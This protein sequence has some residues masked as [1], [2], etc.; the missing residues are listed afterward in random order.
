MNNPPFVILKP[1][2]GTAAANQIAENS[3]VV[4]IPVIDAVEPSYLV[5]YEGNLY[6]AQ[7]LTELEQRIK[8]AADRMVRNYPTIAR[9]LY[10]QAEFDILGQ[11]SYSFNEPGNHWWIQ[12]LQACKP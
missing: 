9:G 11:V 1:K 12:M 6:N 8:C 2:P 4:G 10:P 5:Y 7:N 3:G